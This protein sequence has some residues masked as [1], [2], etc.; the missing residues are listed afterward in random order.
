MAWGREASTDRQSVDPRAETVRRAR[1]PVAPTPP[2]TAE[3]TPERDPWAEP[4]DDEPR[5]PLLRRAGG[6]IAR[7]VTGVVL[8]AT[9]AVAGFAAGALLRYLDRVDGYAPPAI[10]LVGEADA[11]AVLTG[12]SAR[13]AAGGRLLEAGRAGRLLVSGV[14]ETV[15]ERQVRGLLGVGP[16]LFECCVTLDVE[17]L[18]T[19]GNAREIA[20]W[21]GTVEQ[22]EGQVDARPP[23][24][25]VV[26][27]N[28]HMERALLELSR[29]MPGTAL[30][31][32]PVQG[33]NLDSDGWWADASTVR[34]L[35]GEF[36]KLQLARALDLP[37]VGPR[38]RG[39]LGLPPVAAGDLESDAVKGDAAEGDAAGEP[40]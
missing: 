10:S 7:F 16:G 38:L 22:V 33:V 20:A 34:V 39:A 24:L 15:S 8:V 9:I 12:G 29:A 27:S 17:A 23:R 40:A 6:G 1:A 14:N 25:I 5:A 35:A 4:W 31:P 19:R 26:T 36:V 11:I 28:Y 30:V 2:P 32:Y 37:L 21:M 13:I 3:P 18:D